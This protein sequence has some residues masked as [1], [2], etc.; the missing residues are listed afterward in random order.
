MSFLKFGSRP[1]T[2][3]GAVSLDAWLVS[4]VQPDPARHAAPRP[5]NWDRTPLA[6]ELVYDTAISGM[7][8][9]IRAFIQEGTRRLLFAADEYEVLV[10]IGPTAAADAFDVVGQVLHEGLPLGCAAVRLAGDG[11]TYAT[12]Q[13]G[14]FRLA[15]LSAGTHR[16][17]VATDDGV[18][19]IAPITVGTDG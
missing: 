14:G 7:K 18:I 19:Q 17:E 10:R 15:S 2:G 13:T 4:A 16:F 9:G 11:A 5:A 12:D 8:T 1:T 6:A 3:G